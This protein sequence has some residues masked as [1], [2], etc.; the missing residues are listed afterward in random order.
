MEDE[1]IMQNEEKD[2]GTRRNFWNAPCPTER[3]SGSEEF[4]AYP[5]S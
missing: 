3:N 5:F 4:S 1:G 2:K